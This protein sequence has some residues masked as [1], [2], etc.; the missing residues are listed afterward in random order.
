MKGTMGIFLAFVL[1][2]IIGFFAVG[3]MSSV[4]EPTAGTQA[5]YQYDNLTK[6]VE[7]SNTGMYS[8]MLILAMAMA[9]SAI[10]F[11]IFTIKK[12]G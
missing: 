9:I 2:T 6:A 8:L 5:A 1:V 3:F 11:L 12:R 7:I 10:L 4:T